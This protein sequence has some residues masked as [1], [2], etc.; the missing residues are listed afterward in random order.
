MTSGS[1]PTSLAVALL[2]GRHSSVLCAGQASQPIFRNGDFGE[3]QPHGE[4]RLTQSFA[5]ELLHGSEREGN[6]SPPKALSGLRSPSSA[7]SIRQLFGAMSG[8]H[9]RVPLSV[10]C[11]EW[12]F[13]KVH[14][15]NVQVKKTP[16]LHT[17][18]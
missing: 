5:A 11:Q 6:P 18:D 15:L 16:A 12:T 7:Q 10:K 13:N 14:A 3:R 1:P 17:R 2:L 8:C 9:E 4:S